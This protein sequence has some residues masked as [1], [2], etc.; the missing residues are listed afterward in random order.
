MPVLTIVLP[1]YNGAKFVGN[2]IESILTNTFTDFELLIIDDGSTDGSGAIC[3]EYA[4]RDTRIIVFH[5]TNHGVSFSRNFGIDHAKGNW[6]GFID[7]DDWIPTNTFETI[8]M[9]IQSERI[10]IISFGFWSV[11]KDD[12]SVVKLPS[13]HQGKISFMRKQM[14][15]GWTVVWNSF[16]QKNFLD[17]FCLRFNEYIS[18]GEDFEFLFRAYY[19]AN[20]IM[21]VNKPLYY[22]NRTNENSALHTMSIKQY[23]E[24]IEVNLSIADFFK[25]NGV[26]DKFR[27]IVAWKI[28]R[29]KQDYVLDV[30]TH[31]K[32]L[33]I[34]PEC[35]DY[36]LTCPTINT[37][38]KIMMWFLTHR[39]GFLTVMLNKLR[40]ITKRN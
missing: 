19:Y 1:V 16:F 14:L 11:T 39:M 9:N 26:L 21:V 30:N 7:A 37:K 22:Y 12:E 25:R 31:N 2:C 29:A 13:I 40:T 10:D 36:I 3:D 23:D 20:D 35:H 32:F 33:S 17:Q 15:Y 27:E 18:I 24:I 6:V 38:I 5:N 28:L 4:R 34:Y 8:V